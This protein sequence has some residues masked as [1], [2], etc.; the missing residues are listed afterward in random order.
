MREL[1]LVSFRDE[2]LLKVKNISGELAMH[3]AKTET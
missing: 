2:M 1:T 3:H